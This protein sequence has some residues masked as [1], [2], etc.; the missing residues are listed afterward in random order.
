MKFVCPT[1]QVAMGRLVKSLG[2]T[3]P[4]YGDIGASLAGTEPQGFRHD[5]HEIHLGRGTETFRRA[6]AGL[7]TWQAH[8]VPGFRVFPQEAAIRPEATIV[9][10]LGTPFLALAAPCRIV[11]VVDEPTRWGFAYGTLPGHPER[12]EEAFR[13]TISPDDTVLFEIVAFSRPAD[14]LVRLSSPLA[15]GIQK[16]GTSGYLWALRRYVRQD[17]SRRR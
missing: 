4:T 8:T 15:R 6:V 2:E 16:A 3:Q 11:D 12:G 17:A 1:D 13:I 5:R 14:R 7:K 9:V 10:T